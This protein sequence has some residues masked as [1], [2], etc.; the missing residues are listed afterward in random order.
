MAMAIGLQSDGKIILAGNA[1]IVG[2]PEFVALR[3]HTN[4]ALDTSYGVNGEAFV[5]FDDR[6]DNNLFALAMDSGG[7]A[8]IAGDA[9][10]FFGVARLQGDPHLKILSITRLPNGHALLTGVGVP[11]GGHTIQGSANL[12]SP[13]FGALGQATAN[14]TGLWQYDDAGAVNFPRRFYRLAFP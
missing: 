4:G 14:A 8:V 12:L 9:G 10:G 7:R 3:Y 13:S 5:D 6:A 11:N 1:I 2:R